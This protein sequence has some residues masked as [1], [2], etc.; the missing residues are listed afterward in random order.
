MLDGMFFFSSAAFKLSVDQ[1][2]PLN[3][4]LRKYQK[5]LAKGAEMDLRWISLCWVDSEHILI[6]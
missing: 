3:L 5:G 6:Y 1:S 2:F 4:Q